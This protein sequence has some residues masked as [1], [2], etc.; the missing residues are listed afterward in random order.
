M[1][2]FAPVKP[3]WKRS[4][5]SG[6]SAVKHK[7]TIFSNNPLNMEWINDALDEVPKLEA[8]PLKAKD[9]DQNMIDSNAWRQHKFEAAKPKQPIQPIPPQSCGYNGRGA[10][11]ALL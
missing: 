9:F 7:R 4:V 8:Y 5:Y 6:S 3:Y 10:K 11:Q 1:L 2:L